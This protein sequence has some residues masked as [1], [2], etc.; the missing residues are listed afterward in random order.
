M[1]IIMLVFDV[2]DLK[3]FIDIEKW[4]KIIEYQFEEVEKYKIPT[5]CVGNKM[6][7]YG[8]GKVSL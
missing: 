5:I 1:D 8:D 7:K 6:D 2:G 3:S 4:L